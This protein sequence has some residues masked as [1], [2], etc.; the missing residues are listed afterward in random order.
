MSLRGPGG[1]GANR[2]VYLAGGLLIVY[3]ALL[4]ALVFFS[5]GQLH[6]VLRQRALAE[7]E[8]DAAAV[9]Y[10]LAEQRDALGELARDRSIRTFLA[11]RDLGMSM[12]YGLRAS[13][14]QVAAR[15]ARLH[16]RKSLGGRPVYRNLVFFDGDGR[17]LADRARALPRGP[18]WTPPAPAEAPGVDLSVAPG[19]QGGLGFL[20]APV[21]YKGR[22]EGLLVAAMD[23]EG[24]LA[25]ILHH[26]TA[27]GAFA[28][29]PAVRAPGGQVLLPAGGAPDGAGGAPLRVSVPGADLTLERA[30]DPAGAA[31]Y[32]TSP[33]LPVAIALVTPVLL[34]GIARLLQLNNH[35]LVLQARHRVSGQQR[36]ILRRHNERLQEEVQRRKESERKL[37]FQANYDGLTGLPNR[38]LAM[39]RLTQALKQ[40]HRGGH[41]VLVLYLDLDLFK[42][43]NDSLGHLAGDELLQQAGQRLCEAVRESDTV[44]RLGG[45]EFLVVCLQTA[46][47]APWEPLAR[48]LRDALARPFTVQDHEFFVGASIGVA[49][50]PEH[51]SWPEGLLKA[52]D[53]AMYAAK[54]RGRNGYCLFDAGMSEMANRRVVMERHLRR[55]LEAG[56]LSLAYQPIV[57]LGDGRVVSCEALARW[58]NAH[59]GEVSPERFIP[60]AEDTGLIHD[61]GDWVLGAA[62]ARAAAW[63]GRTGVSV[64]ISPRQF[65]RP[66]RLLEAVRSALDA[67]GLEAGRLTL[68]LTENLLLEAGPE[69]HALM[70]ELH[71][72]GVRLSIDDF[73]TGFSALN[74]LHR[75]PF[76]ALK[77]DRSFVRDADVDP[78]HGSLV[79]AILA[80]AE[81]LGLEVVA[82][83]IEREA[84][85]GFLRQAGC[86]LGQGF[87][88]G[89]PEPEFR[90]EFREPYTN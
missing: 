89:A 43:V 42:R 60:L 31:G 68:E 27:R 84:Q 33:W 39:D 75:Y 47:D 59:L 81:A 63:P 73:G 76:D 72:L 25:A 77:I 87:L 40:A 11:N 2:L 24:A 34:L 38:H 54:E 82:E 14:S 15:L 80:M 32:L 88:Y 36:A 65:Q 85:A 20:A 48:S 90:A 29:P 53:I 30:H 16:D 69:V 45:D 26:R 44:A 71:A 22:R 13:L 7:L 19:A 51:G 61:M 35:N 37:S 41:G 12:D 46:P 70:E 55:A 18:P 10:F 4:I 57:A 9:G 56:E 86:P 74:Y 58:R 67:S 17:P 52:A 83:G 21:V 64:N 5:Q 49:H 1:R 66:G 28:S 78:A 79:R 23:L 62:C 50:H 6:Q 8:K 3:L